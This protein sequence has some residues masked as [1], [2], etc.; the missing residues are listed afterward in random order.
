M[1]LACFFIFFS[2]NVSVGI[3]VYDGV[4]TS[5]ITAPA[6]VFGLAKSVK[7]SGI[8]RVSLI[9]ISKNKKVTSAEGL[10][11]VADQSFSDEIDFDVLI[12]PGAYV[13]DDVTSNEPFILAL[14]QFADDGKWLQSNCSGAFILAHAGVLDGRRA[15]TWSGGEADLKKLYPKVDVQWDQPIV[16]DG[17]IL[18]SNGGLV[19]YSAALELLKHLSGREVVDQVKDHIQW[20]QF[21]SSIFQK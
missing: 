18:T 7:D 1:H 15:T 5:E 4:L 16:Q 14:K 19:S 8:S 12:V 17:K 13:L 3:V 10:T 11:V 21:K 20:A 2:G 9:S 6:E